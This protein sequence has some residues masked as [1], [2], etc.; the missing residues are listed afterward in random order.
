M[1][2]HNATEGSRTF[3]RVFTHYGRTD[4]LEDPTTSGKRECRY[5]SNKE[6][7]EV[8]NINTLA[9]NSKKCP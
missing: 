1:E 6:Q 3:W 8:S 2:I 5:V 4:E 9:N 7:A